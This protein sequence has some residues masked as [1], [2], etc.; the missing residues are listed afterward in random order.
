MRVKKQGFFPFTTA[1]AEADSTFAMFAAG[2][3]GVLQ[4]LREGFEG[5]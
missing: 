3:F 1:S 2:L 5:D 4:G